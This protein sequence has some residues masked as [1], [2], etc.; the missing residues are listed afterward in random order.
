MDPFAKEFSRVEKKTRADYLI[1]GEKTL[2]NSLSLHFIR[3][4][5]TFQM[6]L[7]SSLPTEVVPEM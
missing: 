6:K 1:F 3:L 7:N 2:R 5:E 4:R